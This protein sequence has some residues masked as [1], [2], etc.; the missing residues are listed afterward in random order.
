MT[1]VN[2]SKFTVRSG[3]KEKEKKKKI[4]RTFIQICYMTKGNKR[5]LEE[6]KFGCVQKT[7]FK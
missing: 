3:K 2:I 7:N 5:E 4:H 6:D 1:K